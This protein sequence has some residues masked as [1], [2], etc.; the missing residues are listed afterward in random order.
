MHISHSLPFI[1]GFTRFSVF[2]GERAGTNGGR[3]L[4]EFVQ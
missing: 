1:P 2:L 4:G 3:A